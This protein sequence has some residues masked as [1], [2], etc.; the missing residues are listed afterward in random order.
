MQTIGTRRASGA[1]FWRVLVAHVLAITLIVSAVSVHV[2]ASDLG[3]STASLTV[4]SDTGKSSDS[5][6]SSLAHGLV[7]HASCGCHVA[8]PT[9]AIAGGRLPITTTAPLPVP[10]DMWARSGPASLPFEPP[11]A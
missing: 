5:T 8:V 2:H 1:R 10:S 6:S 4:T 3:L 9:T 11:R 7:V